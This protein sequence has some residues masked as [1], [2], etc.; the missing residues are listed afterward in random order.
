MR[1]EQEQGGYEAK[2]VN[3]VRACREQD[4]GLGKQ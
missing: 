4:E 1:R 3:E 2:E